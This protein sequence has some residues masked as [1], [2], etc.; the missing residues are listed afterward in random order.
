MN[1]SKIYDCGQI[2]RFYR[3]CARRMFMGV[4]MSIRRQKFSILR[5]FLCVKVLRL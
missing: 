3:L 5:I 1:M 4:V 2:S